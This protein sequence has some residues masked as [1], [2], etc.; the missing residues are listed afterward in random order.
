[1]LSGW[2]DFGAKNKVRGMGRMG[3]I[4]RMGVEYVAPAALEGG[5]RKIFGPRGP[6]AE[7][8]APPIEMAFW[9]LFTGESLDFPKKADFSYFQ[10]L[11]YFMCLKG[12]ISL[13]GRGSCTFFS[14]FF[15]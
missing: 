5:G 7:A 11:K 10:I 4:G 1:M 14:D 9:P 13:V 8:G 15:Q 3:G 2:C 12:L 6:E